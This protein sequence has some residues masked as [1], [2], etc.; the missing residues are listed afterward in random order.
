[1]RILLSIVKEL[2]QIKERVY[3]TKSNSKLKGP[4]PQRLTLKAE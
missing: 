1:M 2:G 4:C 3:F